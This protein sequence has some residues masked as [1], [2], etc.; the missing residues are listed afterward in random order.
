MVV[1]VFGVKVKQTPDDKNGKEATMQ[2]EKETQTTGAST[3]SQ[4]EHRREQDESLLPEE[5]QETATNNETVICN[6]EVTVY[7]TTAKTNKTHE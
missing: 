6:Q 4:S 7:D 1:K 2:S 5:K 3:N